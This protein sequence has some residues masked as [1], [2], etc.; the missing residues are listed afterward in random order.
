[1]SMD[2][3][4][5]SKIGSALMSDLREIV[6]KN[7]GDPG[8]GL[9]ILGRLFLQTHAVA[10]IHD[11]VDCEAAAERLVKL[12]TDQYPAMYAYAQ[13]EHASYIARRN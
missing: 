2:A 7:G 12:I 9:V 6:V 3:E 11:K 13:R 10:A 5:R 1:M 4:T 8:D